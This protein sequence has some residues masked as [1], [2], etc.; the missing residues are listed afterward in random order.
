MFA[1]TWEQFVDAFNATLEGKEQ[2]QGL[3]ILTE[4]TTSPTL[5]QQMED[6]LAQ[7]PEAKWHQYSPVGQNMRPGR[8]TTGV[9]RRCQQPISS[10]QSQGHPGAGL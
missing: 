10:G 8:S 1:P 3:R 9:W 5:A 7:Y 4:T 6:L 2:G